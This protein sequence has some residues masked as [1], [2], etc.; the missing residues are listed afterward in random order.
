MSIEEA[1]LQVTAHSSGIVVSRLLVL[2]LAGSTSVFGASKP[3]RAF[4]YTNEVVS[5][6]VVNSRRENRAFPS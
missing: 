4:S 2:A 3:E 6:A 1:G 5:N